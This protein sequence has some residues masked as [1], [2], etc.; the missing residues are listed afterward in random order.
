MR[1][2]AT[3]ITIPYSQLSSNPILPANI[4]GINLLIDSTDIKF[5]N[6][7]QFTRTRHYKLVYS[8]SGNIIHDDNFQH[9]IPGIYLIHTICDRFIKKRG[10]VP[11]LTADA[12]TGSPLNLLKEYFEQQGEH[13]IEFVF[14]N[15]KDPT[16]Q[17]KETLVFLPASQLGSFNQADFDNCISQEISQVIVGENY[18]DT[19][20]KWLY[21]LFHN[22]ALSA[23]AGWQFYTSLLWQERA[24]LYLSFISLGKK[25]RETEYHDLRQWY[26][27]EYEVLP[28]WFKRLGHIIKVLIGKRTFRSLFSD[29]VKSHK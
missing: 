6:V 14:F 8:L 1:T 20:N 21:L 13:N 12:I 17:I 9:L 23:E 24:K 18:I 2:D 15:Q 27:N 19:G 11:V 5:A 28:L 25:V 4:T 7:I 26:H 3:F 29:K 16:A 10:I 22:A